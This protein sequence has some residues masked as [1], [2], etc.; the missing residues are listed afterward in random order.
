ME[1]CCCPEAGS[2]WCTVMREVGCSWRHWSSGKKCVVMNVGE[3]RTRTNFLWLLCRWKGVGFPSGIAEWTGL[4]IGL[5]ISGCGTGMKN[6]GAAALWRRV[7]QLCLAFANSSWWG[8]SGTETAVQKYSM[9]SHHPAS[10]SVMLMW[11]KGLKEKKISLWL[12][13]FDLSHLSLP[14]WSKVLT[15]FNDGNNQM[16]TYW[17]FQTWRAIPSIIKLIWCE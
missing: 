10:V 16:W 8:F 6:I 3:T 1:Q 7:G 15:E 11:L 12:L 9:E 14:F 2:I 4:G 13:L 17:V 5:I